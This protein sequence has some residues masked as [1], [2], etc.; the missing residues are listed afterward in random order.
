MYLFIYIVD[1]IYGTDG[2][3]GVLALVVYLVK[4][5]IMLKICCICLLPLFN[6]TAYNRLMF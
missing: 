4:A 2:N 1:D 3:K 5:K 6:F